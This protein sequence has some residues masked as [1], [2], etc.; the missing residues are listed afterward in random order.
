MHMH[1]QTHARYQ[2][3]EQTLKFPYSAMDKLSKLSQDI[4]N[5]IRSA[6]PSI[7]T[8][9]SRPFR[10][11]WVNFKADY[12]EVL[13]NAHFRIPPL[14]DAYYENRQMCLLAIDRAIKN[15]D[16]EYYSGA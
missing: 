15:N 12:L 11:Y 9:G 4:K 2:I 7:I 6:C 14:G 1:T 5:E 8:D 10:C 16:I 3:V 13:I